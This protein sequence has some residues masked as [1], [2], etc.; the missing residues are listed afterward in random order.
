M[1]KYCLTN[2]TPVLIHKNFEWHV[3]SHSSDSQTWRSLFKMHIPGPHS[4]RS[5]MEPIWNLDILS[6]SCSV[7]SNSLWL[8]G[9]PTSF[10]CPWRFSRQEYWSGLPCPLQ[11][12]FPTQGSNLVSYISCIVSPVLYHECPLGG[13]LT[14]GPRG[15]SKVLTF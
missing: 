10:L 8:H 3:F 11:G 1:L 2:L 12:I 14:T 13:P 9:E 6:E 4:L 7:M 15:I 5:R